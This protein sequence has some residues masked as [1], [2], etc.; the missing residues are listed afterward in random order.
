MSRCRRRCGVGIAFQISFPP[1]PRV[2]W[3]WRFGPVALV[4]E[5]WPIWSPRTQRIVSPQWSV[6][7]GQ[8]AKNKKTK[9][10][11][12]ALVLGAHSGW[13]K[14]KNYARFRQFFSVLVSRNVPWHGGGTVL[15]PDILS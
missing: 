6:A 2:P 3:R 15:I 5:G 14:W 10:K 1:G 8:F 13:G 11:K 7:V 4:V 12:D 9:Q